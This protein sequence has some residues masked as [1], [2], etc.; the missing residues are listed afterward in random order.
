[1]IAKAHLAD[2]GEPAAAVTAL[3]RVV[4]LEADVA[5]IRGASVKLL[6]LLLLFASSPASLSCI[7][8]FLEHRIVLVWP[9]VEPLARKGGHEGHGCDEVPF[10][11]FHVLDDHPECIG[12]RVC[13]LFDEVVG[14]LA[15]LELIG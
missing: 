2:V 5:T 6:L 8:A 3:L 9:W 4:E 11:D 14:L 13:V 1:V 7:L 15:E 10:P 12:E